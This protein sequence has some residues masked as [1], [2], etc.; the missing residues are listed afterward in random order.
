MRAR[1][2]AVIASLFLGVGVFS[3]VSPAAAQKIALKQKAFEDGTGSI[4]VAPGWQYGSAY[5]GS[6]QVRK[7]DGSTVVLGMPWVLLRPDSSVATLP[8]AAQQAQAMP[9]DIGTALRQILAKNGGATLKSV[10][11]RPAPAA[12]AGTRAVYLLYD[13][14]ANG[15][16]YTALGYFTP[17]IYGGDSPSWQLYSSAVI[18]PR[19]VFLKQ[20]PTMMAMWRSWRPNGQAPRKGSES[21]TID[22]LL[23]NRRESFERIQEAFRETL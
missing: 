18:A 6:V 10:R 1:R 9:G 23:K 22:D 21:A 4:G 5:R 3:V 15:K 7:A 20:L 14:V 13:F 17:L 2:T 8:A 11:S 16:T 12:V 19:A